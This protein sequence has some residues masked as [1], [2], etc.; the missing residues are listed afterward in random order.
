MSRL[1]EI[2]ARLAA[3]TPGPWWRTGGPELWFVEPAEGDDV[4]TGISRNQ[5]HEIQSDRAGHDAA[6]IASAPDDIAYLLAEVERLTGEVAKRGDYHEPLPEDRC[7]C[8]D[9]RDVHDDDGRG[10]CSVPDC[11]FQCTEFTLRV[12]S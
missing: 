3:A 10:E 1:D 11:S 4:I 6:L 5:Y 7:E 2:R 12:R 8:G 9:R